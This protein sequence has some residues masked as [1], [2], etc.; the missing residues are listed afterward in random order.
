MFLSFSEYLSCRFMDLGFLDTI[1]FPNLEDL[2][3]VVGF[4]MVAPPGLNILFM[5]SLWMVL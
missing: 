2:M 3:L 1:G 4:Q 5:A